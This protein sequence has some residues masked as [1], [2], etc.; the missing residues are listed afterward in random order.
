MFSKPCFFIEPITQV[1]TNLVT[2]VKWTACLGRGQGAQRNNG[3]HTDPR[4][5]SCLRV[6]GNL[7]KFLRHN[8][9]SQ[10]APTL[11]LPENG[12]GRE[13]ELWGRR[14]PHLGEPSSANTPNRP[15]RTSG[16]SGWCQAPIGKARESPCRTGMRRHD[17]QAP[18]KPEAG[19]VTLGHSCAL[20]PSAYEVTA[21][22]LGLSSLSP[23]PPS[24]FPWKL[25]G[26][27]DLSYNLFS[28]KCYTSQS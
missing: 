25:A 9:S 28:V 1:S 6:A 11:F 27:G 22:L 4:H 16:K 19:E 5:L 17:H 14:Q 3:Q 10:K 24:R 20:I 26:G 12:G 7:G 23:S 2:S 8:W 21:F 18:H 15:R 13:A